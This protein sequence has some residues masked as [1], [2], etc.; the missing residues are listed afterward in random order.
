M[1][2]PHIDT[3]CACI[4]VYLYYI[5]MENGRGFKGITSLGP[6]STVEFENLKE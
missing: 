4:G 3:S 2:N 6:W 5:L 1:F